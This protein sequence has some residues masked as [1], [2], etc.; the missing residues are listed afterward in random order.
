MSAKNST[1]KQKLAQLDELVAWFERDD[2][3]IE[4]ALEKFETAQK[5]ANEIASELKSAKNKVEIIKK[6]FDS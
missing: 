6:K 3:E 1:I 5:L 2:V 4:Q